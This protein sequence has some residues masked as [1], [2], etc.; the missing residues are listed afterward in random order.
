MPKQC[1]KEWQIMISRQDTFG[2]HKSVRPVARVFII[3]FHDNSKVTTHGRQGAGLV[4]AHNLGLEIR[5]TFFLPS[6]HFYILLF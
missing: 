2:I 4:P 6:I 1:K 5:A 3:P